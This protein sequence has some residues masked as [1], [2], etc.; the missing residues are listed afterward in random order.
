M[1]EDLQFLSDRGERLADRLEQ[2][3]RGGRPPAAAPSNA[4]DEVEA[5]QEALVGLPPPDIGRVRS[6]AE[7]DLLKALRMAR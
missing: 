4:A 7:R 1:K 2:L 5:E 3:V 6:Q